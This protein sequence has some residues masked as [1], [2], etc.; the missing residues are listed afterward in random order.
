MYTHTLLR[1]KRESTDFG[2]RKNSF[3]CQVHHLSRRHLL[4]ICHTGIFQYYYVSG[5]TVHTRIQDWQNSIS[6]IFCN[7]NLKREDDIK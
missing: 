5:K 1:R 3:D 4:L 6:A 7:S 2:V